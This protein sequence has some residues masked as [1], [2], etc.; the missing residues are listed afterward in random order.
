[1][2][3][4]MADEIFNRILQLQDTGLRIR[5]HGDFHLGQVLHTGD[6]HELPLAAQRRSPG[7]AKE[8]CR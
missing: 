8:T 7:D 6:D 1:M 3:F 5:A 2:R 4:D